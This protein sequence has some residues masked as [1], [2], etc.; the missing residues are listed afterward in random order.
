MLLVDKGIIVLNSVWQNL[1]RIY[2]LYYVEGVSVR[3]LI[4]VK[5]HYG[6]LIEVDETV[7]IYGRHNFRNYRKDYVDVDLEN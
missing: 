5:G 6:G 7:P 2:R 4:M 3:N 1:D